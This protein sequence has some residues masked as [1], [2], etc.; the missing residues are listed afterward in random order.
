MRLNQLFNR[1]RFRAPLIK[2]PFHLGCA[3]IRTDHPVARQ[4]DADKDLIGHRKVAPAT[5]DR[6]T[7]P[8]G[9]RI[10]LSDHDHRRS[11]AQARAP[12][13]V[14]IKGIV[15]GSTTVLNSIH[16]EAP[17]ALGGRQKVVPASVLHPVAPSLIKMSGR[18]RRKMGRRIIRFKQR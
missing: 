4:Q 17:E 18:L 7:D 11:P 14:R 15:E 8:G 5:V 6:E 10:K 3:A 16:S 1:S 2:P 13:P 9:S 12:R